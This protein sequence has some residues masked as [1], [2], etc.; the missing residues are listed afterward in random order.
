[1]DSWVPHGTLAPVPPENPDARQECGDAT[2][3]DLV[4]REQRGPQVAPELV[5]RI[6]VALD[7][8]DTAW[9]ALVATT[10][11]R[12]PLNSRRAANAEL[13]RRFDAADACLREATI[14]A[15]AHSRHD[16]AHWRKRLADLDTRRQIHLIAELDTGNILR[17]NSIRAIDTG[18]SGPDIGDLQHGD[19][20]QPGSPATY[21][22]DVEAILR[23]Q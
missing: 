17:T 13:G 6:E 15:R 8:V 12:A 1:M 16:W 22:V 9:S 3:A 21:G 20:K 19:T 14:I 18:M 4:R 7:D 2:E 5:Q 10:A 11:S 23:T